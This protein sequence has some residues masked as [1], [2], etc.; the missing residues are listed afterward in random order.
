MI[1]SAIPGANK[2]IIN[3]KPGISITDTRNHLYK[4]QWFGPQN[5]VHQFAVV[6]ELLGVTGASKALNS[7]IDKR[8]QKAGKAFYHQQNGQH[9]EAD[10]DIPE[11][12]QFGHQKKKDA[13][14]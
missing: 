12:R 2:V 8:K 13:K 11:K 3:M 1:K 4:I 10:I 9:S 7:G 14:P 5:I 6:E